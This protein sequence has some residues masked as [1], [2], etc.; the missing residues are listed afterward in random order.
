MKIQNPELFDLHASLCKVLAN[1]KRLM[2]IAL[3]S[4][5][6]MS[7]GEIAEAIDTSLATTSQ[8]LRVLRERHVVLSRKEGQTVYYWLSDVRLM[9]ACSIIRTVLLDT[10]KSRGRAAE[11]LDPTGVVKE[12]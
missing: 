5:K 2:I 3:V 4:Q 1:P 6:E 11:E 8:H 7:V 12:E 9:Q 10:M